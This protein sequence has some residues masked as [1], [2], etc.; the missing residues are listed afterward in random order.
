M[1]LWKSESDYWIPLCEGLVTSICRN[2][3]ADLVISLSFSACIARI[4]SE[5]PS[6]FKN[7]SSAGGKSLV[8]PSRK[9]EEIQ[10]LLLAKVSRVEEH[11][12][13][14][15]EMD[16]S[17][18]MLGVSWFLRQ[19][20]LKHIFSP[21]GGDNGT[22]LFQPYVWVSCCFIKSSPGKFAPDFVSFQPDAHV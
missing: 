1:T 12:C 7:A 6:A 20:T 3:N 21:P 8:R 15:V 17:N 10:T 4:N 11:C 5:N 19:E 22:Y 9:N 16:F 2:I 14:D 18:L 13:S